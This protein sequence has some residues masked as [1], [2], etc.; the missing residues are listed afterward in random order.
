MKMLLKSV[1]ILHPGKGMEQKTSDLLIEDGVIKKIGT[2]INPP[3]SCTVHDFNGC[4][5]SV[6]WMDM[7]ADFRDPGHEP[8]EGITNGLK[9]AAA[10]GFTGVVL[11][12]STT[13]AIQTKAD[14]EYLTGRSKGHAVNIYPA[15]ALSVNREGVDITEMYDMKKAGAVAF[16]DD[17]RPVANAGLLMRAL[18]Y[19]KNIDSVIISYA[20]DKSI[21]GKGQVHEGIHS[22]MAGLKGIPGFSEVLMIHRDLKIVE[23]TGGRLHFSTLSTSGAVE[24]IRQ[25]KKDGLQV[26]AEVTAGHLYFDDS[27]IGGYDTHYKVIPPFRSLEDRKALKDG[28]ADGTIDV[29]C[30]DHQPRDPESK[31]TEFEFALPGIGGMETA[32]ATALTAGIGLE[33]LVDSMTVQP[34]KILGIEIPTI[35]EGSKAELTIF[36]PEKR[37]TP[38]AGSLVTRSKNNPLIDHELRGRAIAIVNNGMFQSCEGK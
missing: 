33:R 30:S 14:I 7:K 5:V 8:M 11:M 29:V 38:S 36:D 19:A 3:D 16:T 24:L 21:S 28:V 1:K 31:V 26:T 18:L 34:R 9:V 17:R 13:P 2:T 37:W 12:P 32:F 23:Y 15:G 20:D 4:M 27:V 22:T 35:S 10:A 6:G 25:A